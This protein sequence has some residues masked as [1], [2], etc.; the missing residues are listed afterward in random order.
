MRLKQ[1]YCGIVEWNSPMAFG[2]KDCFTVRCTAVT[3][4]LLAA[5]LRPNILAVVSL[6]DYVK[7]YDIDFESAFEAY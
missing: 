2:T 5:I 1:D 7:V 6:L 3:A 4:S